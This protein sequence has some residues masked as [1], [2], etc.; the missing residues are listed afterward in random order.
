MRLMDQMMQEDIV[1]TLP[2]VLICLSTRGIRLSPSKT[3]AVTAGEIVI[4]FMWC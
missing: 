3:G 2:T 4:R 1:Y